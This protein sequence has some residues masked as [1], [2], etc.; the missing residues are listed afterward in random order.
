MN[1]YGNTFK[2][3]NTAFNK[4]SLNEM[5]IYAIISCKSDNNKSFISRDRISEFSCINR[6]DTISKFTNSLQDNG[7]IEKEV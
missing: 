4:L 5:G 6:L 1:K 7:L 2:I 3:S